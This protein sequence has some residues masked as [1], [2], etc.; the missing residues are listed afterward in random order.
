MRQSNPNCPNCLGRR[1]HKDG[2]NRTG[3]QRYHCH[4]CNKKWTHGSAG[5]R[6]L[7]DEAMQRH[8]DRLLKWRERK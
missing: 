6:T 4:G 1:V 2:V 5:S 3:Q 7:R 8:N